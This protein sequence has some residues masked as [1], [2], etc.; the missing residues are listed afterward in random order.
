LLAIGLSMDAF[1]VAIC[2]GLTMPRF[3]ARRAFGIGLYFGGF[4]A[5]MPVVGYFA[6]TL[7]SEY[8]V[9]FDHWVAFGLLALIG[10]KMIYD[11]RQPTGCPDRA[12]RADGCPDRECPEGQRP[13]SNQYSL[14]PRQMLPLA[15]ATSIDALAVGVS[16][17]FLQVDLVPAVSLICITTMLL[18]MVGVKIGQIFGSRYHSRAQLAGGVILVLIGLRILLEHLLG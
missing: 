5:G 4:Q 11:S 2:A 7:F 10:G 1:S 15:V 16:F 14:S 12:C 13:D 3:D 18:S 6:A 17:A 9:G 8:I